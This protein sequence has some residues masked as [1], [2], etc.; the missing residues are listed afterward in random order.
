MNMT[1]PGY[2]PGMQRPID[3]PGLYT[4]YPLFGQTTMTFYLWQNMYS[5]RPNGKTP[6]FQQLMREITPREAQPVKKRLREGLTDDATSGETTENVTELVIRKQRQIERQ[7]FLKQYELEQMKKSNPVE[8]RPA[9]DNANLTD[10]PASEAKSPAAP[11]QA[12]DQPQPPQNLGLRQGETTEPASAPSL[13]ASHSIG[14]PTCVKITLGVLVAV[15][16]VSTL[17]FGV[18]HFGRGIYDNLEYR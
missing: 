18:W 17:A 7:E 15:L 1:P 10:Q 6:D 9:D 11:V 14:L 3:P 12:S 4:Q 16:G 2:H 13:S 5:S 8:E